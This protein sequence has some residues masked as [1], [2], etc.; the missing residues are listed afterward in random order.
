MHE[1]YVSQY[2]YQRQSVKHNDDRTCPVL[3]SQQ[4]NTK[5]NAQN[6]LH[7]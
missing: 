4:A 7:D 1:Y 2:A 6:S 5:A 3:Q